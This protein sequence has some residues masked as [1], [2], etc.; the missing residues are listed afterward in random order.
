MDGAAKISLLKEHIV[1]VVVKLYLQKLF[2]YIGF[3]V[4]QMAELAQTVRFQ[5][6]LIGRLLTCLPASITKYISAPAS[7]IAPAP[8]LAPAF[9]PLYIPTTIAKLLSRGQLRYGG[10]CRT[11]LSRESELREWRRQIPRQCQQR[12]VGR[13]YQ[14]QL[15]ER[16]R[17]GK[18]SFK[19]HEDAAQETFHNRETAAIRRH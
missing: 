10:T 11:G 5:E 13:P 3:M 1:V 7:A 12:K 14:R 17:K 16:W 2:I 15:D 6:H 19:A 9:A 4:T 8:A 18:V